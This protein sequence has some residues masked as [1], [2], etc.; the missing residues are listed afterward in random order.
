MGISISI[1]FENIW[2]WNFLRESK[3]WLQWDLMHR[4][5]VR[6]F[7]RCATEPIDITYKWFCIMQNNRKWLVLPSIKKFLMALFLS[8]NYCSYVVTW[9]V[10][11]CTCLSR[12]KNFHFI[13]IKICSWN[14]WFPLAVFHQTK[15][16]LDGQKVYV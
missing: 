9:I 7:I 4:P 14:I 2:T 13:S 1:L 15:S 5:L 3:I 10:T 16:T 11:Q 6:C 12:I 8:K